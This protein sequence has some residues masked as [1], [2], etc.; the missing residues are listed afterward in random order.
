MDTSLQ[1][2]GI[3]GGTFD[4]IHLG[5]LVIAE[6]ALNSLKLDRV[7]FI[8]ARISPFKLGLV[9][10]CAENRLRMVE[11]AIADNAAFQVSRLEIDREGPSYTVDTLRQLRS[12]YGS[13]PV[14]YLLMGT[15]SLMT[16][17]SWHRAQELTKL[18]QIIAYTRPGIALD[19][20]E[21]DRQVPGLAAATHLLDAVKLEISATDLR[22]RIRAQRTIRYLVPSPVEEYIREH[23]LYLAEGTGVQPASPH[24]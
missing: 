4:P 21:L 12:E 24:T 17:A 16:I 7:L 15:D 22:S 19:L 11:L 1:R 8:P 10:V 9:S 5:H 20:E 2:L 23:D 14:F 3:F 6:E 18:A 13:V